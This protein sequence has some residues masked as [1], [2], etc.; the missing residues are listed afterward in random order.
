M[1]ESYRGLQVAPWLEGVDTVRL[2]AIVG[3]V[4]IH[5]TPALAPPARRAGEF[6][7]AV[8][9]VNQ[10]ARFAVPFFFTVSGYFWGR[11]VRAGADI[12]AT[13]LPMIRRLLLL[14][15]VWSL[16][17]LLPYNLSS[18]FQYGIFGP[19][20]LSFWTATYLAAH[21]QLLLLEGTHQHLWFLA[22][23]AWAAA[24]TGAL[25]AWRRITTLVIL[26]VLLYAFGVVAYA[27]SDTPLG[28]TVPFCTRDGPFFGT[29]F[30]VT[31]YLLSGLQPQGG[32][33]WRGAVLF[34][35]GC[36]LHLLEVVGLWQ[37][38]HS[39]PLKEYVFGTYLMG[40]GAAVMALS[41]HP[42]IRSHVL[43]RLGPATFGV[44]LL[45]PLFS[46]LLEPVGTQPGIQGGVIWQL[47]HLVVV[48]VLTVLAVML[49]S[50]A[51]YLRWLMA[52][53][54][55]TPRAGPE[56]AGVFT[57]IDVRHP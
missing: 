55:H 40:V 52:P 48:L 15:V 33:L 4:A 8:V 24:L 13:T 53:L 56:S 29:V 21:P 6:D 39:D 2:I 27:Y 20:K 46:E 1:N 51:S 31:G 41:N 50:R 37:W 7:L 25:V 34:V 14:Y 47:T 57:R 18:V 44:Y 16:L 49:M 19:L 45:N 10:L 26:A 30:F 11:K 35:A 22:A 23:L 3:V 17:Y 28:V 5:T 9:A 36:A 43:A 42:R 38:Y 32:W 12:R 54:R